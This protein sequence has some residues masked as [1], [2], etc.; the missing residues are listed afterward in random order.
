[1]TK[2]TYYEDNNEISLK[3]KGHAGYAE[4]GSDIVCSAISTLGQTLLAY[5]NV[6][7]EKFDYSMREGFIWVYAKGENVRT[8]LHVVLAGYHLIEDNY[9]D[10]LSIERGCAIQRTP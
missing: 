8:A 10:H 6:D 3:I 9:P 4:M 2:V 5:L 1:M 7:H